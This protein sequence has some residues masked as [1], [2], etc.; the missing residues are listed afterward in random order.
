MK[1]IKT[2]NS[3]IDLWKSRNCHS[4]PQAKNLLNYEFQITNY[5]LNMILWNSLQIV[6]FQLSINKIL[7]FTQNDKIQYHLIVLGR[8]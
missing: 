5:E 1:I 8:N 2:W 3:E 7:R 4:E 6:N